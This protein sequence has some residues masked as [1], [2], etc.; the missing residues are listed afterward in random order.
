MPAA[1]IHLPRRSRHYGLGKEIGGAV[2]VHRSYEGVIGPPLLALRE[3]LPPDFAYTVVKHNLKTGSVTF[4]HSF[5]FDTNP[6]P[7]V[8]DAWLISPTGADT[9]LPQLPD[10]YIYHH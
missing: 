1:Q 2:Y 3:R 4:I 8:G 6:E 10:P 7:T 9:F 5:D